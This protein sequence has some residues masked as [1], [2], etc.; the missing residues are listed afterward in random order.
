MLTGLRQRVSRPTLGQLLISLLIAGLGWTG[1]QALSQIDQDLRLMYTEYTL[2]AADLAHISADIIRYRTTIIRAVEATSKKDFDRIT[3][4]LPELRARVQHAVDRYAGA[5]LRVSRSGRSEPQDIQAVRESLDAYFSAAS[6]TVT[7]LTRQWAATN[8]QEAAALRTQAE[9]HAAD[10][11]GPK[12]IQVSVALDRLL[13]T[14][15]DV[16]KDMRDEGT[17]TIRQTSML[18]VVGSLT[19]ALLNLLVRRRPTLPVAQP[20]REEPAERATPEKEA[21]SMALPL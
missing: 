20:K 17:R 12:L 7:L 5:S 3:L 16:A 14:I 19:L 2:G 8:P 15:A 18:L 10:N 9:V 1:A 21:P 6:K 4:S 13:E 11:A